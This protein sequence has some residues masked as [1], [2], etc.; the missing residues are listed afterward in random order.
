MASPSQISREEY[1]AQ[2]MPS[3][4]TPPIFLE[5]DNGLTENAKNMEKLIKKFGRGTFGEYI[6]T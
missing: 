3:Q 4:H 2:T 5:H 6:Y 1:I